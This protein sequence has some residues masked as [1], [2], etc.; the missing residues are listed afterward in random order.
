M[1]Y[2]QAQQELIQ[3]EEKLNLMEALLKES[4]E[5]QELTTYP[6]IVLS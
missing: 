3:L 5:L 4:R 6:H 1:N 2:M